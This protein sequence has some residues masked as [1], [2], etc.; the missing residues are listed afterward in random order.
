LFLWVRQPKGERGVPV[1]RVAG[2][3]VARLKTTIGHLRTYRQA[4]RLL[5]ARLIYND[6][7]VTVFAFASIFAAAAFGMKT[8]QIIVFGISVNVCAALGAFGLGFL[9]DRI[10]GK[11]TIGL[12]LVVLIV[13]TVVG[14]ATRSI[15]VFWI[16]A[17]VLG[18]MVGP[19]QSASRSL[20]GHFVPPDRHAEFFGFYAFSG[21]LASV[22][23]PLTYGIVLEATGSQRLAMSSIAVFFVIGLALLSLVDEEEG[24]RAAR[25]M[26]R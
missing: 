11:R 6:G 3:G 7:L 23:G 16:S 1:L 20:L 21:R 10:G 22:L 12:T 9:D 13:C 25:E 2:Q 8:D 19:N 15:V 14:A 17:L 24:K 26:N 4:A 18:A 5:L